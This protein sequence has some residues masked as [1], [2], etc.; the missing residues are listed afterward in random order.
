M[1]ESAIASHFRKLISMW[2][3]LQLPLRPLEPVPSAVS[4][5]LPGRGAEVLLLGV[6]PDFAELSEDLTAVDWSRD[7]IEHIWPGDAR[8]R[9]AV[10]GDWRA[11]PFGENR[12]DAAVGD[13]ALAMLR[14]PDDVDA[15]LGELRRVLRADGVAVFRWFIAAESPASDDELREYG[16]VG[17]AGSVEALRWRLIM[18]CVHDAGGPN[19]V[20]GRAYETFER[21]FPDTDALCDA[22]GWSA[23][24][25]ARIRVY[26]D[27]TTAFSFP[28]E[29]E[30][31]DLATRH[32]R[33]VSLASSGDYPLSEMA[34]L[35]VMRGPRG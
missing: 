7:M 28:T 23:E 35:V 21:L 16:M 13:N 34:P 5:H 15:V 9:R 30:M 1:S 26:R 8:G 17:C 18:H 32:F 25:L 20:A 14:L 12:F 6:T 29:R 4:A 11:L 19:M 31:L 2:S 33:D 22:H 10:E 24:Q 27:S 3:E